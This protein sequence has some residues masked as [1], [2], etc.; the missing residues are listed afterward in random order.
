MAFWQTVSNTCEWGQHD[1][2]QL[3][4]PLPNTGRQTVFCHLCMG[5]S[6]SVRSKSD[7]I[8]HR[9]Y[10]EYIKQ[11]KNNWFQI[12]FN[13]FVYLEAKFSFST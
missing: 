11:Q 7:S 8:A 9:K 3:M 12:N 5:R 2:Q 4:G 6:N 10:E 1:I 13:I